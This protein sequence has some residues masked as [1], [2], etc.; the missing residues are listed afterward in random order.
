MRILFV[1]L[2]NI[3]RSPAAMGT[4]LHHIQESGLDGKVQVDSA[5][6]HAYH[7][8]E[9]PNP[10]SA[11]TA[12]K[13]GIR[14]KHQA[15]Q[16][17]VEDFDRFDLILAMDHDNYENILSKVRSPEDEAKVKLYRE[18][19]PDAE[20]A[21]PPP[22]PDPYYGGQDGFDLVQQVLNRTTPAI[23]NFARG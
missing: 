18:F 22:V 12:A 17:I 23:L 19:D 15:R 21:L 5:G 20:G 10:R 8:G 16:F 1:C 13:Y 7:I 3:C 6:T 11:A 4:M 2:G 9:S 14:L